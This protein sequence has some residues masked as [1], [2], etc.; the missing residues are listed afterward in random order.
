LA[1]A[2]AIALMISIA[3]MVLVSIAVSALAAE[4]ISTISAMTD[5][6]GILM[7]V[8]LILAGPALT[9]GAISSDRESG[10]WDLLR[11]T[12]L[13]AWRIVS[14][15]LQAC[16]IP[17]LLMIIGCSP[18]LIILVYFQKGL[19]PNII[20]V[21]AVVGITSVFVTAAGMFF[22]SMF[23]KTSVATA[24]TYGVVLAMSMVTLLALL[25]K[26]IFGPRFMEIAFM[27]NPI[28]AVMDA[29]GDRYMSNYNLFQ[30]YLYI[31]STAIVVFFI[32]SVIRVFQLC[33]AD[34]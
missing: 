22:S 9:S 16:F 7:I 30:P 6:I 12:P 17:L 32:L 8:L 1:R 2:T 24:W 26:D 33:R 23:S 10:V 34:K 15:K 4:S 29:A 14:G 20:R 18:A 27:I 11:I 28:T 31:I 25:G 21:L 5:A 3:L 13:P 19:L